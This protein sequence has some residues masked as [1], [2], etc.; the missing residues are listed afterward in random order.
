M[1]HVKGFLAQKW[2]FRPLRERLS[3]PE[4]APSGRTES[5]NDSDIAERLYI[6]STGS[7]YTLILK[8]KKKSGMRLAMF[9]KSL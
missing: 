6:A 3:Q 1:A 8:L 4:T 5:K 7:C 9:S 2:N